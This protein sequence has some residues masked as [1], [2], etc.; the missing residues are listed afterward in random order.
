[1]SISGLVRSLISFY[2]ILVFAYVILSWFR[3]TGAIY[4]VYRVL[5]QV[6]EPYVGI[7]RRIVPP[8]GNF[9]FSPWIAVLVLQY[10]IGP[11]LVT[12]LRTAGL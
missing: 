12:L 3:P 11:V 8:M 2:G 4:D 9:D 6:C 1:M 7:F 5:A 10:L